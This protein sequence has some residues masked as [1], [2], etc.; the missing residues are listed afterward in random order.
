MAQWGWRSAGSGG[1]MVVS[2]S[3]RRLPVPA[4]YALAGATTQLV[5]LSTMALGLF[6]GLPYLAAIVL[7]QVLAIA[8][9]FPVYRA[10]VF[11]AHGQLVR[12]FLA[13]LGVWWAGA[14]ASLVGVPLLV[15]LAGLQPFPAQV[16]VIAM[17]VFVSFLAH[18]HITFASRRDT[19]DGESGTPALTAERV[20]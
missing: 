9:A 7:A 19:A 20:G 17:L 1:R 4:R 12:Q 3:W 15:E 8:F 16:L 14:V 6:G 13:F 2:E 18:R 11:E 10:R 5:Y